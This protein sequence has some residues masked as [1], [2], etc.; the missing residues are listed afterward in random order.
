MMKRTAV[1]AAAWMLLACEAGPPAADA[2]ASPDDGAARTLRGG[3]EPPQPIPE[4]SPFEY[5]VELWEQEAEGETMLL[6]HVTEVG[7]VDTVSVEVSSGLAAFDSAAARGAWRLRF[8]PARQG[9]RRIPAWTRV[10]VRFRV[11]TLSAMGT[12]QGDVHE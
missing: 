10:P 4:G 6:V 7:D 3:I 1:I 8:S 11:D 5:P 12:R 9:D 2:G